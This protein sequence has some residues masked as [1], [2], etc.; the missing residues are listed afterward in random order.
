MEKLFE[1]VNGNC[2]VTLFDNGTR[3][4]ETLDPNATSIELDQPLS[5]DINISNRCSIG[6]PYCYAGNT[7]NGDVVDPLTMNYL[8]GVTGIEIA[9]NIQ[10]PVHP[11]FEAW[12][13]KMKAQGIIVSGTVNQREF[14]KSPDVLSYIN[15]LHD[16]RLLNGIGVSYR[17]Y[18]PSLYGELKM[19][20]LDD[21]VVHT[22]VGC[23]P[24][25]DILDL[26]SKGFKVLVLGYKQK[27]RGIDYFT[28]INIDEWKKDIDKLINHQ[29]NSVLA[30]D[31]AGLTQLGIKE[32]LTDE[33]WNDS[34]QGDEGTISFY[35]DAVK[36]TFNNNSHT[37]TPPYEI[38]DLII[39]QMFSIIKNAL[40]GG[41]T[42]E[43][44]E[45]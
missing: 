7:P 9:I 19:A 30:F 2:N 31:T 22:I 13:K 32:L 10:F 4:V 28:K 8:D 15:Y 6:C 21:I 12:L 39:N 37:D 44:I 43:D 18:N 36:R 11:N 33:Q 41:D 3:I 29:F 45:K 38:A 24:I 23:T 16:N 35:I 5:L 14:E 34:Y 40:K 27:N 42:N 1:I 20:L 25:E 26:L 17:E